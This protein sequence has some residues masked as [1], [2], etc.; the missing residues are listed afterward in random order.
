MDGRTGY[1]IHEYGF[2]DAVIDER[3]GI[4][5]FVGI[6]GDTFDRRLFAERRNFWTRGLSSGEAGTCGSADGSDSG[7]SR[8]ADIQL[9]HRKQARQHGKVQQQQFK[10]GRRFKA[11]E[12][13]ALGIKSHLP[14]GMDVGEA[15]T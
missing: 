9:F 15:E 4:F 13:A 1:R 5:L 7:W 2:R 11:G 6:D 8:C 12:D 14:C 10:P 3:A